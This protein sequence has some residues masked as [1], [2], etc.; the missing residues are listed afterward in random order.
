LSRRNKKGKRKINETA[1]LLIETSQICEKE[2]ISRYHT[3]EQQ[4]SKRASN[5]VK[6]N[7]L[8]SVINEKT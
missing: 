2:K 3:R 4:K 6:T 7:L 1:K 5:T 8:E